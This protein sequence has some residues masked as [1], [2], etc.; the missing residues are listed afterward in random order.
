MFQ[1]LVKLNITSSICI[2]FTNRL[3]ISHDIQQL[4]HF[5]MFSFIYLTTDYEKLMA[6]GGT[7]DSFFIKTHFNYD[8]T[9]HNEMGFKNGDIFHVS[10]TLYGGVVGSYY[11]ARIGR[12]NQETQKGIIPNTNRYMAL[13]YYR[14]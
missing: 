1:I 10:D 5:I 3:Y 2:L 13:L 12:N 4:L 14:T 9:E 8:Q 7:G 6:S 11:A